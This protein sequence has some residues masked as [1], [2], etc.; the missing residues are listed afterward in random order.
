MKR[1][2]LAMVLSLAMVFTMLPATTLQAEENVA[3]E[4]VEKADAEWGENLARSATASA[5]HN[6]TQPAA[7]NDGVLANG[8]PATS[9]NCWNAPESSYP[10]PVTL[11]W[12][13]PQKVASMRVMW[14]SDG[15]GVTWP[16]N[17]KV[18]YLDGSEWKDIAN[19]GTEHGGFNGDGGVWNI[20]NFKNPVTTTAVRML[21]GRNVHGTTG[22]GISEWEV[23]GNIIKEK[24][25]QAQITGASKVVVGEKEKYVA[26]TVPS[27]L[28]SSASY[29]WSVAPADVAV[30]EG[31]ATGS[32]ISVK[33]LKEGKA[34]LKLKAT[35]E[36]VSQETQI[37]LRVRLEKIQSIDTY[38]TATAA[39]VAPILPDSVVANGLEF[40]E[41]TPSLKSATKPDFDF[42][43]EFN[44]RLVPVTWEPVDKAKYAKGQEGKAFTVRGT[45]TYDNKDYVATALVTVKE[46]AAAA[47]SNSSVTFENVQLN[48]V[49]WAP[50]QEVNAKNSLKK[51]ITEIEKA[52]GGEPNYDNAIK[53]L[54]G[55]TDYDA[56]NGY[57][58]QDSDIYKSIEAIS[59]TL[60]ATQNDTDPEMAETRKFLEDKL[61]SWIEKIEKVQYADGYID[62]FFTLRSQ[63]SSGGGSPGT[64][65][66]LN[67]S[68]H[69]MYNA[70]HFLEGVV[71]YT[72]YREGIGKP[73][74]RL[75]VAGKRFADHIVET[76]G[77]AGKR[78]EVPG[79]EEIE[80]ALVKF[81][82]LAEEYEGKG[83]GQ[84]YY[85]TVKILVDRRGEDR[86]LRESGYK[87]GT[88]SQD[89][90]PFKEETNAVGHAVRAN[91]FYTG[92]TDIA[93]LLPEG[94]ADRDAYLNSLDTICDSVTEKKTYITGAIGT[95]TP[96]SDSEGY[97]KEYDLPPGQSYA[98]IC[99][100]IAAANWN[101]RMNLL[102]E[103]AKYADMVERNL[104]NSILVGTNLDG[105]RFYYS[106]LLEVNNGQRRSEWFGCACCPPNL[107]R[108]IAAA[109]GYMY[110]VHKN[111]LFVNMYIGSNGKVNVGGTQV[112][113]KQET[114]YPWEGTVKMTVSPAAEKAFTMKIRIPGWV[115]EQKNK[116]VTI[117]VNNAPVSAVAEKGY[118][119]INRTWKAGDVVDID[120]PMEVRKTESHPL[121]EATQGEVALQRGPVVYCMEK[122][123]NAQLNANISD[124]NPLNFVIPRDAELTAAYNE[125]LLNGVVEITGDVKYQNG[126][127]LIDAKLQAVP[128]YAWNNRGDDA[129]FTAGEASPKNSSSKMLIWTTASSATSGGDITSPDDGKPEI[130]I[131]P[132]PQLRKYAKPSVNHVGWGMGAE[133]FAD[134][135]MASFWNGHNDKNL[136][137][138]NQWMMY[139]FEQQKVKINGSAIQFYDDG[140]GVMKP[141]GF[142]IEYENANGD[143][144]E[145]T[146]SGE[147]NIVEVDGSQGKY[148]KVEAAF[149]EVETSKIRVTMQHTV[150]NGQKVPVAVS[151]WKLS[152]DLAATEESKAELTNKISEIETAM[153]GLREEDYVAE[154][155]AALQKAL[156]DAKTAAGNDNT[157]M[158]A[159]AEAQKA[160][161][162]AFAKLD[163]KADASVTKSLEA[164]ITKYESEQATY[165]SASWTEFA[166]V[167]AEAKKVLDE[168]AGTA[169][170][171]E[172]KTKLT[173]AAQSLDKKAE[174]G[175]V[176]DLKAA[177]A[178]YTQEQYTAVSWAKFKDAYTKANTV[179]NSTDPGQK[180]VEAAASA[181]KAAESKLDKKA[182]A[183]SVSALKSQAAS[184]SEGDYTAES[185]KRFAYTL[186]EVEAIANGSDPGQKVIDAAKISLETAQD[187]LERKVSAAS[188]TKL[189]EEIEKVKASCNQ[190]EFTKESWAD[191]VSLLDNT[192]KAA[193]GSAASQ[194]AIDALIAGINDTKAA[195]EKKASDAAVQEF[196]STLNTYKQQYKEEDFTEASWA[197]L[198]KV[199]K[200]A[201]EVAN[202]PGENTIKKIPAML[203]EAAK[204]VVTM[205]SYNKAADAVAE[206]N[207]LKQD[208]YT[209]ESWAV[210]TEEV[211][212]AKK[213]MNNK[214]TTQ[215][216]MDALPA[217]LVKAKGK[218][219]EVP[220]NEQAVKDL[221]ASITEAQGK[222]NQT[223]YTADSWK[224]YA[225][226]L[227]AAKKVTEN[228]DATQKQVDDAMEALE[229]AIKGLKEQTTSQTVVDKKALNASIATAK[230]KKQ[231]D[232]TSVSWKKFK[233]A[234]TAAQSVAKNAKATQSQVNTAK[235]NLD[236]AMKGLVK[237]KASSTKKLTLGVGET[238]SVKTKNCTYLSSNTKIATVSSKGLVK[239]KKTGSAVVKAI[240]KTG[241]KAKVFKIT[242]KKAPKKITKVT[243]NK[244]AVKKNK[245]TLKK[246]RKGTFKVTLPKGTASQIKYTSSKKKIA[247][248]SSKG[249]VKAKK[250]GKTVI[251][252]KTYNKKTKKITLT[253]K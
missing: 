111:D 76:F 121:V 232:Y 176:N 1:R 80:L 82:K 123:G 145:V 216:Q 247:T 131:V 95:T 237:L 12:N 197:E 3:V 19:A 221:N 190:A 54:N 30:I 33:G 64:H 225:D 147:W 106:T 46:P 75:Y 246:G 132:I 240:P 78:H 96:G 6:N 28:A 61:N 138:T 249:V 53:K 158:I 86:E 143:W 66:W 248:I 163:K 159:G 107:M 60:S 81:G 49:F 118:V 40:D 178:G 230:A 23:Y 29:E 52:S 83:A 181:L 135:D 7:I 136:A 58:F 22:V 172:A 11:T 98:E 171:N 152:G 56:F 141:D 245:V 26:G 185:W 18:Q 44:S 238:Y 192:K 209:A 213:V 38:R 222:Y 68:N 194:T 128:Y 140:G 63:S 67:L 155:W 55:E 13:A 177:V 215:A 42:A 124:F 201:E 91:Y 242:V 154:S 189:N 148:Y 129:E 142:T 173:N 114:A 85:D 205:A 228:K 34:T 180:E 233:T 160:L 4:S 104:Y 43:E 227:E 113:L 251:T 250:K 174:A 218:L 187:K 137:T 151:D 102:H 214:N 31:T 45:A 223:K 101:Q 77:P 220:A 235:K 203:E 59:Y 231:I 126:S 32:T 165:S 234:L 164:L 157:G 243:F 119:A 37:A 195:L 112:T 133:N 168:G 170:I 199:L 241:N 207:S 109:S 90:T 208:H 134:D 8:N 20:V 156:G 244:K 210:F 108:T 92:V 65:R 35:H 198:G 39:G 122:A 229:A 84:D 153:N 184:F 103:D 146:K 253:V 219:V 162:E 175:A 79:H 9:W 110:T 27:M 191:F 62:T 166:K 167:L 89:A 115:N 217:A 15:G 224:K 161:V 127:S 183:A 149:T 24:L 47:E 150:Y 73:D 70:G 120:M 69:E 57:V 100:A 2:V 169:A 94:N 130:P 211:A 239:A 17:A 236:T 21:V 196:K 179:A 48:D 226:A 186:K 71:A 41:P 200:R 206:A 125:D 117:K 105:N 188:V 252:I 5:A 212:A 193:E 202:D 88:Y 36:G 16:S 25:A 116:T 74:Y 51:A 10:M 182:S 72:R 139:D 14:W 87:A 204:K 50:K 97:G 99:A 93:T 144:Q